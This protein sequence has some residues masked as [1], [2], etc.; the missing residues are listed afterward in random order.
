M[1]SNF[2]ENL[3]TSLITVNHIAFCTFQNLLVEV[4]NLVQF[5]IFELDNWRSF[6]RVQAN[7]LFDKRGL[8]MM[9][10]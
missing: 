6:R 4:W 9:K 8:K 10:I 7:S 3:K 2:G 5:I 1:G